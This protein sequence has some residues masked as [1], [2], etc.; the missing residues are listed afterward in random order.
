V[1]KSLVSVALALLVTASAHAQHGLAPNGMYPMGFAGDTWPGEVTKTD[2]ATRTIELRSPKGE[3]FSGVIEDGYLVHPHG[4][5]IRLLKVSDIQVGASIIVQ[6][7]QATRKT[8]GAK[9]KVNEIFAIDKIP[10]IKK[11]YVMYMAFRNNPPNQ[12]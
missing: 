8:A 7:I 9:V 5:E 6:Y 3:I 1:Y 4:G 2:E 11:R 12:N 10:N